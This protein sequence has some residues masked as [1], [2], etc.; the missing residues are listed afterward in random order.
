MI[1][2]SSPGIATIL[3]FKSTAAKL[4]HMT[5]DDT[6]DMQEM[7]DMVSKKIKTEINNIEID[8]KSYCGH[9]NKDICLYYQSNTLDDIL[10]K[11]NKKLNQSL[12]ALLIGNI[13]TSTI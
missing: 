12:P 4:F 13:I 10:T 1:A 7:I 9:V 2:L 11:V 8:R 6:D 3:A 5:P